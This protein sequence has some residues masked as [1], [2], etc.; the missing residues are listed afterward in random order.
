MS[1]EKL[2]ELEDQAQSEAS[3]SKRLENA[4]NLLAS[5]RNGPY[6]LVDAL[7]NVIK[8]WRHGLSMEARD[9]LHSVLNE[10]ACDIYRIAEMRLAARARFH[11]VQAAQKRAIV[12]A[13]ILPLPDA[14]QSA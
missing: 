14:E 4:K 3:R 5:T 6:S 8:E 13:S 10:M 9:E 12:T 2:K 1:L 11:K 7:E